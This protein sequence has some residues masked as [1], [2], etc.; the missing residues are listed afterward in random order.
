MTITTQHPSQAQFVTPEL[1]EWIVTQAKAGHPPQSVLQAMVASGWHEDTAI[2]AMEEALAGHLEQQAQAE[3]LPPAV[4]VPEPS[5]EDQPNRV[6]A[7][8]R[9]V[10]VLMAQYNPRVVVFGDL[11]THDECDQLIALSRQRLAR[12]ETVVNETGESRVDASRTSDGMFFQRAEGE[13]ITRLEARFAAL[14][15]W[16]AQN[17]EGLQILRYGPGAQ[18]E[19]HYDWFDPKHEG[20]PTIVARGG[21]RVGTLICYLQSPEKGGGTTFPD[22]HLEVAPV[23]GN[24]VFFSYERPHASTRTLHGGAPVIEGE[25]WICT[26]WLREREF[27]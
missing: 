25:K 4:K 19:P 7:G 16:P 24:A 3:G 13:L 20:T 18:Y 15:N 12:S 22:I 26:K 1:R 21:Q 10:N 5:L 17:G 2:K 23:K 27:V 8:D 11:M 9:W 6:W 14:L